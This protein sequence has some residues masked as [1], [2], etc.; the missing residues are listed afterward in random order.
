ML[1]SN[2]VLSRENQ[3]LKLKVAL[4][5]EKIKEL[6]SNTGKQKVTKRK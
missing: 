6:K 3:E 2:I 1:E 5:K 4:L